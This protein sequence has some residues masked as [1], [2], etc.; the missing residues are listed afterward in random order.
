MTDYI[1]REAAL[2]ISDKERKEWADLHGWDGVSAAMSIWSR[3]RRIPAADVRPVVL[4]RDCM[5]A[6]PDMYGGT[7]WCNC[8]KLNPDMVYDNFFCAYGKKKEDG[9]HGEAV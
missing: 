5:Y 1:S 4:C 8:P 9:T 6:R 2:E 7:I 3:I